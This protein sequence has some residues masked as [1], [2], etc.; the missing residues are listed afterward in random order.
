MK[1]LQKLITLAAAAASLAS[2]TPAANA[3][4]LT[5]GFNVTVALT[6]ACQLTTAPGT[7]AFTYAAFQGAPALANTSFAVQCT[8]NLGYTM[9]LDAPGGGETVGGLPYS[10]ILSA[11]SGTGNGSPQS[12][13]LNGT[14]AANLAGDATALATQARVLTITY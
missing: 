13:N 9:A 6:S 10:L 8:N 3:V 5:P 4:D 7:V 1:N 11:A 14:I 12:F 2:I